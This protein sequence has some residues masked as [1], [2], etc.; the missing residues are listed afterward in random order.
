DEWQL[1][2]ITHDIGES[3]NIASQKPKLMSLLA[4]QLIDWISQEHPTWKP[5]L[6]IV[7]KTG[8]PASIPM[9]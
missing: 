7:K 3:K 6:P 5:K 1:Y 4:K 2:D 8:R 9:P